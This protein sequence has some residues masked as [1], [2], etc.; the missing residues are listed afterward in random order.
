MTTG[1]KIPP[2]L[3]EEIGQ[4][5]ALIA[6]F[7]AGAI[8]P[9]E[10][11]VHRVPFGV[12]EQR[13][14]DTYM[15]RI[16]CVA[17]IVTPG[18]LE[19]VAAIAARYGVG[20]LHLTSR[21][22]LQIHYVKLDDLVAVIRQLKEAGLSTR[23]GGGNTVRNIAAQDD[24]GIDPLEVFDVTP[25]AAALTTRLIA[26]N[27]S[28]NLPRKY[29]IAFSGS[30]HDKGQATLADLGFIA[31]IVDGKKGFRVHVAGG[32]GVRS[33]VGNLLFDFVDDTQV[34]PIA[35][36][37][38]NLFW[39]YG[40][41]K[42]KHA[43]RLRFL[44]QGLGAEEFKRRFYE[45]FNKVTQEGHAPLTLD[46]PQAG[47]AVT[48]AVHPGP[49][50][51]EFVLWRARYVRE[52]KQAGLFSVLV[53]VELGFISCDGAGALARFLGGFG[54]D[55]VRV[56]RGQNF[57]LRNIP[58]GKL[59]E[60]HAFLVRVLPLVPKPALLGRVLSCAGA[61]TCQL[62]ICLSRQ[63][64]R[65]L[66][67]SLGSSGLDLD[68]VGE[69]R[70]N[71]SGCPNSCGHH[72]A[73]DLGFAGKALR[74]DGHMYPAYSVYAGAVIHDGTTKLAALVGDIPARAITLVVENLLAA[75]LGKADRFATF[76]EYIAGEGKDDLVAIIA[77]YKDIPAFDDDKN[78]YFDWSAA[79]VFSLAERGAGEC[80]TGLF[81]L[82]ELDL[83]NIRRTREKLSTAAA[84]QK[85][86]LL[87][88]LVFFASRAL[89]ITRGVEPKTDREL[90]DAF[91][92]HF[93]AAGHVDPA[94][95]GLVALAERKEFDAL[96]PQEENIQALARAIN[97]LY[98]NM[99]NGFNF[100]KPPVA[101]V[102]APVPV[103]VAA[104]A[105]AAT[106]DLRGVLCPFNFVKTKVELARLKAGD[107]LEIWLDDGAPIENVPGSVRD[108]GHKIIL[109]E[110]QGDHWRVV[111]EKK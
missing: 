11:K 96:V 4:L 100:R 82:I 18:Q 73:A 49:G 59:E 86:P 92:Q 51:P 48:A 62:G 43:A 27:D 107:L 104:L 9:I 74:K 7:R 63:A 106:K 85:G 58:A 56:T 40:N 24:A 23:G 53:P 75:F 3:D 77:R 34:Y 19:K 71:I 78:Y 47:R 20:D 108:E 109:Q 98:E 64:A 91:R 21:Q 65:A 36:A 79:K 83:N 8:A 97:V 95:E 5:E 88:Q 80:S 16:R 2:Q 1:Y 66:I 13:E 67:Q 28:W 103:Q 50:E 61:S 57:L 69:I 110:R 90:Y 70:L 45:E 46:E 6:K 35:K 39:K 72:P 87:G 94:F 26:E 41:R 42:N 37:V 10:L 52:Q 17:G 93:I 33:A 101:A 14:A 29:K 102:E 84:D 32:L 76:K 15:V 44:W 81:D 105:P 30:E 25:Y 31:R 68:K 22:E 60:V 111:I 55:V 12:Y 89:L 38:K 99:D 54:D